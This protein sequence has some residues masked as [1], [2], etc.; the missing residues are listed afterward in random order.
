MATVT[1]LLYNTD[2]VSVEGLLSRTF[3]FERA[4]EA[5]RWLDGEPQAAVKVALEYGGERG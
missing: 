3:P 1:R 5:Y 4:P 2:R